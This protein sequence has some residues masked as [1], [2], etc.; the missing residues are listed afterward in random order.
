MTNSK[1]VVITGAGFGGITT[2]LKLAKKLK[3][4]PGYRLILI[5]CHDYQLYTPALYEIASMPR[6]Y[7]PGSMIK[8]SVTL[9]IATIVKKKSIIS[10]KDSVTGIS[11]SEKKITL[12]KRGILDYEYLVL[13]LGSETN[14]FGI[15][16]LKEYSFPLKTFRDAARLRNAIEDLVQKEKEIKIVVGGGGSSGVELISEFVNFICAIKK[17]V[18]KKR[19]CDVRFILIES[20]PEILPGFDEWVVAKAKKRLTRLGIEIRTGAAIISVGVKVLALK[21]GRKET[22]DIF[23]W[24]GGVKGASPLEK[25]GLPLS[26]KGSVIIDETLRVQGLPDSVFAIGDNSTFVDQRTDKPL[27]WNVPVAEQEGRIAAH[28]IISLIEKKPLKKIVH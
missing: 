5:D 20:S 8:S 19:I 26:G 13:A 11:P 22:F 16:G 14:Y 25:T 10:L 1:N 3:K 7:A 15:P 18:A 2:A 12:E 4:F 24:T 9:P 6:E 28:N 17:R 27:I 23:I 21:D